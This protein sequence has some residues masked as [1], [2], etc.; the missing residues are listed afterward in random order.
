[1][2]HRIVAIIML[3]ALSC[4]SSRFTA[5][6]KEK[7]QPYELQ[8]S[9]Q[10]SPAWD[11]IFVRKHGWFGGDGIFCAAFNGEETYNSNQNKIIFW[12]SDSM[13]GDSNND[14]AQP[15]STMINNSVA[16]SNTAIPDSINIHFFS[17]EN[18]EGKPETLFIPSTPESQPD[19]FYWLGDGFVNQEIQNNIY[20]FGYRIKNTK[21]GTW[22][23]KEMGNTVIVI[24]AAS[25]PPFA[26]YKQMDI[27]FFKGK[28]IDST[29][30]F[31]AGILVNT[32]LAG[33]ENGDGY[34]YIYGIRGANKSVIVARVIPKN[35]EKFDYWTFWDGKKFSSN[36]K[37]IVPITSKAGNELSVSP[38][39][40]GKYILVSQNGLNGKIYY[41]IG[42]SPVGPFRNAVEIFDT[43]PTVS[44]NANYFT[45]NAKAHPILSPPGELL[46]SYNVNSFNFFE[47]IL[48]DAHLYRPRFITMKY[49]IKQLNK[50]QK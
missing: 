35:I 25:Q 20:I 27:P 30:M 47:D 9:V 2:K 48:T 14:K 4:Q 17:A 11:K 3:F 33:A 23:F 18:A 6:E 26:D 21:Q 46:I 39:P 28:D 1:M 37:D 8:V 36:T 24:P 44:K 22:G 16:L 19:E 41:Q 32:R 5:Q 15:G 31:G 49:Q 45:Y 7:P 43:A 12:F 50:N 34:L 42:D 40:G 38:L 29:G 13:F 10:Q